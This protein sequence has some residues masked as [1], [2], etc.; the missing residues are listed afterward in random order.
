MFL[1]RLTLNTLS[2]TVYFLIA[3]NVQSIIPEIV[4]Q[5]DSGFLP[6]NYAELIPYLIQA[7]KEQNGKIDSLSQLLSQKQFST[8]VITNAQGILYQNDP[9]PFSNSTK[10]KFYISDNVINAQLLIFDMNGTE[11][12]QMP[13]DKK[14]SYIYINS[15]QLIP[16]MYL[17]SLICDGKEVDTKKMILTK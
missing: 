6:V 10:I 13:L 2:V 4:Y 16:G 17:Y 15:S 1:S 5:A 8:N 7:V 12:M 11:K 3:Q 14:D 9:N